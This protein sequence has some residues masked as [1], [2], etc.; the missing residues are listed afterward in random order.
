MQRNEQ[1]RVAI[2]HE[3]DFITVTMLENNELGGASNFP[4]AASSIS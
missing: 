3:S 1:K 4:P 2:F